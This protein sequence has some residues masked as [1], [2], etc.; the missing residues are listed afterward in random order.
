MPCAVDYPC[1][2]FPYARQVIKFA[3]V[4]VP[5]GFPEHCFLGLG[6]FA[7]VHCAV[8]HSAF[9]AQAFCKA[10]ISA[11]LV[12]GVNR[13]SSSCQ[14]YDAENGSHSIIF[15]FAWLALLLR[16]LLLKPLLVFLLGFVAL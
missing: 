16:S 2:G 8:H 3:I 15:R 9:L 10:V 5:E 4:Y 7:P 13:V 14:N 1:G 6:V 11:G 12:Y